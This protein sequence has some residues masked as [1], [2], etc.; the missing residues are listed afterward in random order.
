MLKRVAMAHHGSFQ[1]TPKKP[2]RRA[3]TLIEAMVAAAFFTV[4]AAAIYSTAIFS[5]K[6]Q[7]RAT[8]D[9]TA[10]QVANSLCE[11]ISGQGYA[12]IQA[13]QAAGE[14]IVVSTYD[15]VQGRT[16][17]IKL[18]LGATTAFPIK[19]DCTRHDNQA[20]QKKAGSGT[21]SYNTLYCTATP[22]ITRPVSV[23]NANSFLVT[24]RLSYS[25]SP[26]DTPGTLSVARLISD[27]SSGSASN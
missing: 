11:Q 14:A 26:T 18:P 8:Q 24:L 1:P 27:L 6:T 2:G 22:V 25:E 5:F 4:C 23:A 19:T 3:L 21:F 7:R 12:A 20:D 13:A 15:P 16:I 10:Y 17:A 9:L